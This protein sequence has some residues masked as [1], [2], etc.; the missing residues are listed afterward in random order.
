MGD[1]PESRSEQGLG[2]ARGF[3]SQDVGVTSE[4]TDPNTVPAR[5]Y[6]VEVGK[7]VDVHQ[8]AR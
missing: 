7:A 5:P 1:V 2:R 8:E 6:V 4:S 3:G